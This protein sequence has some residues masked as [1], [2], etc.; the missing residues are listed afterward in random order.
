MNIEEKRKLYNIQLKEMAKTEKCPNCGG[1][2]ITANP[3]QDDY[4]DYVDS[5]Y[6]K[7]EDVYFSLASFIN[8]QMEKNK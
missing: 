5:I 6:C 8:L 2:V 1:S 4:F 7:K 3:K